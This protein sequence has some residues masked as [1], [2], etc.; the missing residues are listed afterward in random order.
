MMRTCA[1]LPY[2]YN[3]QIKGHDPELTAWA[4]V[5]DPNP[6]AAEAAEPMLYPIQ[7]QLN[8]ILDA[9]AYTKSTLQHEISTMSRGLGLQRVGD[10]GLVDN[11][12]DVEAAVDVLQPGHHALKLQMTELMDRVRV[13]EHCV[14]DTKER[15][16][17]DKI[18]IVGLPEGL[19]Q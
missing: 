6:Y 12:K 15:N 4:T 10:H 17:H 14:I 18:H 19:E 1:C 3:G 5:D 8:M 2:H 9:I 13:L 7:T 11:V 16:C